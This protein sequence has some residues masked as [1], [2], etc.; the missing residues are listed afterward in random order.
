MQTTVN[1]EPDRGDSSPVARRSSW[2]TWAAL[3]TLFLVALLLRVWGARFGL[4][5]YVYHPDEHAMVN[6]AAAIL[7]T[8]DYSPHWFNYPSLYIYIQALSYIPHFLISAAR[9]YGNTVPSP[10]PYGFYFAGRLMTGLLG[11][12]TVALVYALG[13]RMFGRR[14][15]LVSS[16][17]LTFNLLHVVHS[18]YA[19]TDVPMAFF[20]TLSL[21]FCSSG[22]QEP[23]KRNT[24]LAALF[25]GL[26]ASTKYPGAVVLAPVLVAQVL[27]PASRGWHDLRHRLALTLA[28]FG[29]GF[30]LGTP[31]A[32][33]ELNTFLSSLASVLGHYG[34][35]QPGFEGSNTAF[36]YPGRTLTSP[37]AVVM[38][39]A[40]AAIV[41]A[42][43]KH[44]RQELLLLSLVLP[45]YLLIS[46]WP[47]RFERNLV[48]LLPVLAVLAARLLVEAVSWACKRWPA[49]TRRE[50]AMLAF[51]TAVAVS[52]PAKA[53]VDFDAALSERDHRTLAAE[54][55]NTNIPPGSKIVTEAFS[56]PLDKDRF[57]II[58]LVRIDSEEL[59]WYEAQGINYVI[60]SDGHWRIL[61]AQ[62]ES[63]A[64]EIATYHEILSRSVV[65]Q[66]F[67]GRIPLLL[68][69]GYPTIPIYHF[70][71]VLILKFD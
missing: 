26:A 70:P 69:R 64:R 7:R 12:L 61:F 16:A 27:S 14:T 60:V 42:A 71:D 41:W 24:A 36:W 2:V 30:F 13:S 51:A 46:L 63:Y 65:L 18:H 37:D 47:V 35:G 23:D 33:L 68:S 39:L 17:L 56:I 49:L 6:R 32:F 48:P 40:I 4:P 38:A 59:A 53:I 50:V 54:W 31:Y 29:G 62:P 25:A 22:L 19:T 3:T 58:E 67:P 57:D 55:V 9:G 43:A 34:A 20:A 28:A 1:H 21:L 11:A 5:E 8:G 52:M 66:E 44:T 45:F 10:A 15:G